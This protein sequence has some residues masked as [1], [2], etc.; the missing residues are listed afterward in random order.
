[1]LAGRERDREDVKLLLKVRQNDINIYEI[2]EKLKEF[3]NIMQIDL[4]ASWQ[5]ILADINSDRGL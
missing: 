4:S 3:S 1:M 2:S 5:K